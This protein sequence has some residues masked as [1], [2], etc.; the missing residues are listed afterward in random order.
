MGLDPGTLQDRFRGCLLGLALGDAL[1]GRFEAQ[2]AGALRA[3]F[4]TTAD[5]FDYARDELWY[6]DD[7]QMMIG[8]AE[9][10]L[11]DGEV[12]EERL[13]AAF[14]ANYVPSRGYGRGARAV[15]EAMEEGRDH[16]A[17]AE[18]YFPGGSYGNGAAM[19]VAPIG[20]FFHHDLAPLL[21]QARHSALPT[22]VHPLGIE[23]ARL[24]ALG[25]ALCLRPGPFEWDAF[26]EALLGACESPAF[27][28][29]LEQARAVRAP[30]GFA[31]LGNGIEALESV[32]TALASFALTPG[33]YF[34]AI[35]NVIFLGGDTDTLAAMTG[36]LAGAFLG[37]GGLPGRLLG[38]LEN[39]PRGRAYLTKLADELCAGRSRA[40]PLRCP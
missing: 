37:E 27:R 17:V 28:A 7:T 26:W 1:G 3:R 6:T 36:A 4:P 39:G 40:R 24:L 31:G 19:R 15:L 25:V 12:R 14:A 2:T 22:H 34:D 23:G 8:V 18:S 16:R 13:C 33:S 20:L 32:P 38:L 5:L 11:A 35:A 21:E 10:L 9:A 30:E 29:K